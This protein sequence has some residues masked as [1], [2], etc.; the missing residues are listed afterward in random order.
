LLRS[1]GRQASRRCSS[2]VKADLVLL[3]YKIPN[4]NGIEAAPE[5]KQELPEA[6]VVIFA[7]YKTDQLESEAWQ[8]GVRAVVGKEL[9][10]C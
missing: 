3:D 10:S 5:L 7:L 8:A 2:R 9:S 4:K 6:S 1:R